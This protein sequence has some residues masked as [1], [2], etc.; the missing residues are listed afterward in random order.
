MPGPVMEREHGD[1]IERDCT[2]MVRSFLGTVGHKILELSADKSNVTEKRLHAEVKV[3]KI[4]FCLSGQ[5][6][7]FTPDESGVFTVQRNGDGIPFH[8]RTIKDRHILFHVNKTFEKK[9]FYLSS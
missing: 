5:T 1:K 6:D 4:N 9:T 7:L 8:S 3:N 2:D